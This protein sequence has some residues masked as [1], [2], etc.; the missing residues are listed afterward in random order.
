MLGRETPAR[1]I[2]N[3]PGVFSHAA[4][5]INWSFDFPPQGDTIEAVISGLFQG[6]LST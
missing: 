3:V 4:S 2:L 5:E 1:D 6:D